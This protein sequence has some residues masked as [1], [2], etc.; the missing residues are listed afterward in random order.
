MA[1]LNKNQYRL[2]K[3]LKLRENFLDQS[4]EQ[5]SIEEE[6]NQQPVL[7]IQKL[8]TKAVQPSPLK[9]RFTIHDM[10]LAVSNLTQY[11]AAE[12]NL[13]QPA[14]SFNNDKF[15]NKVLPSS[16]TL[17]EVA[18][19]AASPSSDCSFKSV[20]SEKKK[21]KRKKES[22]QSSPSPL[23]TQI[24]DMGF[25]KKSVENAIKSLGMYIIQLTPSLTS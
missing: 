13:E 22:S 12:C 17:R 6:I 5:Q 11:L 10:Q 1:M 9:P 15:V 21:R 24:M 3:V 14:L 2:R 19:E 20:V 18:A 23:V 7:L 25:S 4:E 8:L 16:E